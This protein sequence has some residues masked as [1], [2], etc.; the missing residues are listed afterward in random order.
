MCRDFLEFARLR[1]LSYKLL[2]QDLLCRAV[3]VE[4]EKQK[5]TESLN[6]NFSLSSMSHKE[7]EVR[8]QQRNF[9][10]NEAVAYVLL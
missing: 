6:K 10:I 5:K 3:T 2:L 4:A 7:R 9:Y 8:K 1:I